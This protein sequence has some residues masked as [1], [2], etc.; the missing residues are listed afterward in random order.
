MK[1]FVENTCGM[2][3]AKKGCSSSSIAKINSLW[4]VVFQPFSFLSYYFLEF[5]DFI[6]NFQETY[7]SQLKERYGDDPSTHPDFNPNLWLKVRSSSGPDRN[8]MDELSNTTTKNLRR[9][10]SISTLK[11]SQSVPST[12]S[13]EFTTLLHQGVQEHT[14]HLN[15]KYERLSADYEE[16]C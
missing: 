13:L 14:A 5:D 15:E 6:F 12:Q 16:L 3:T 11:S 7:N 2:E 4:Y 9:T 8:R 1:L 10:H